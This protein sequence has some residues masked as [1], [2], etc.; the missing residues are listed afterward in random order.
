[1]I[2]FQIFDF[3]CCYRNNVHQQEDL[4]NIL[5][6]PSFPKASRRKPKNPK[7]LN[8]RGKCLTSQTYTLERQRVANELEDEFNKQE[9]KKQR[10]ADLAKAKNDEKI[11]KQLEK[12]KVAELKKKEKQECP[13]ENKVEKKQ[14]MRLKSQQRPTV[15]FAKK[16]RASFVTPL[17]KVE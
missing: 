4:S 17:A 16:K 12:E 8:P 6:I 14:E 2:D 3:V 15:V 7:R 10:R 11:Q 1:M 9:E 13:T 5:K